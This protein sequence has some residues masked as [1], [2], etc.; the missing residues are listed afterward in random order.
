MPNVFQELKMS[1]KTACF[2]VALLL[3][4]TSAYAARKTLNSISE[5]KNCVPQPTNILELLRWFANIVNIDNYGTIQLTF[6]PDSDYGSHYYGNFQNMLDRSS[7]GY[8]YYTVGNIHKDSSK[9]LPPYVVQAR[10]GSIG[11]NRARIIFSATECNGI[12]N[13]R[14]VYI[15]QHYDT[16]RNNGTNY[17]PEHTYEI[18]TNLLREFRRRSVLEIQQGA[19]VSQRSNYGN[20]STHL[21]GSYYS[22]QNTYVPQSYSRTTDQDNLGTI[23]LVLAVCIIV[24]FL[25]F[26]TNVNK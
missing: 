26:L 8:K 6:N 19:T 3:T 7:W 11:W 13:I 2:C 12:W 4:L 23:C 18:T 20:T 21:Q 5:V 16:P 22:Y 17:D 15:T 24:I 14:Q 25:I 9:Q 10:R 1:G